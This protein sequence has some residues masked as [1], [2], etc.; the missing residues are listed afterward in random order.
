MNVSAYP[1]KIVNQKL[2]L[3][4][5]FIFLM[6]TASIFFWQNSQVISK[7]YQLQYLQERLTGLKKENQSLETSAINENS[8]ASLE[9]LVMNLGLE[10]VQSIIF[11][12][13]LENS[14]VAR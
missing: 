11:I 9:E 12:Q 13:S 10:K 3:L 4:L 7:T 2:W 5:G 14:V 1:Y 6:I 8:L